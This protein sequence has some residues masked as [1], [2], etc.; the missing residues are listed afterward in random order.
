MRGARCGSLILS[1]S[2]PGAIHASNEEFEGGNLERPEAQDDLVDQK[3]VR[4]G[5]PC[6]E[7][8]C[9]LPKREA[10]EGLAHLV[11]MLGH[12]RV[13][14][15]VTLLFWGHAQELAPGIESLQFSPGRVCAG[16]E[17]VRVL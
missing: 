5:K 16:T 8:D 3:G 9:G 13:R 14:E 6:H 4:A 15:R 11:V 12:H 10:I 1:A 17:P 7:T 2:S